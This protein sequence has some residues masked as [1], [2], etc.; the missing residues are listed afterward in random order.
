MFIKLSVA[1]LFGAIQFSMA[2][3]GAITTNISPSDPPERFESPD[4]GKQTRLSRQKGVPEMDQV[5]EKQTS[6]KSSARSC[7]RV[8]ETT[9]TKV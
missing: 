7:R 2:F 1:L 5:S 4:S 6:G 3:F 8:D 9:A